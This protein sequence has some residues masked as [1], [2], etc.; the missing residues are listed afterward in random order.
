MYLIK[1]TI[2]Q[3]GGSAIELV[4]NLNQTESG[5]ALD[6]RQGNLL[7]GMIPSMPDL[8]GYAKTS[9]LSKVKTFTAPKSTCVKELIDGNWNNLGSLML[10]SHTYKLNC[11]NTPIKEGYTYE[12]IISGTVSK[13]S[14][15]FFE[16]FNYH[17]FTYISS[18]A[19]TTN[20]FAYS[21]LITPRSSHSAGLYP[22]G[23]LIQ[24]EV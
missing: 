8:S 7:K 14:L 11:T 12:I 13:A 1:P 22:I 24:M 9:D 19:Y 16:P 23:S 18:E 15:L 5:K 10:E 20:S 21:V 2:Q 6:A 3:G 17:N 4:D